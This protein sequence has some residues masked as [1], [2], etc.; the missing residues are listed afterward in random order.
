LDSVLGFRSHLG[1]YT[2]QEPAYLDE[3]TLV[4]I[5]SRMVLTNNNLYIQRS[6][7]LDRPTK[8]QYLIGIAKYIYPWVGSSM[9]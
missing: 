7:Q 2:M 1:L 4:S 8:D 6:S 5:W 3:I 9:P